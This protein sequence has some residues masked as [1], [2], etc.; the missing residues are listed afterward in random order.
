MA[1]EPSP[2]E[3]TET[4]DLVE[5]G[6]E[7]VGDEEAAEEEE[8]VDREEALEDGL[9]RP[10]VLHLVKGPGGVVQVG[11]GEEEGV[12]Q[13]HPEAGEGAGAGAGAGATAGP[14]PGPGPG[15]RGGE[16]MAGY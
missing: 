7:D 15:G 8:G 2:E 11:Q 5:A 3:R 12:T 1:D 10:G 6:E 16:V 9:K 13:D 4:L 14:G